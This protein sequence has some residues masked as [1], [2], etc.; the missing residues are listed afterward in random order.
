MK[1]SAF[2]GLNNVTDPIRLGLGWLSAADNVNITD[3]GALKKRGGFTKVASSSFSGAFSTFDYSRMYVVEAGVLMAVASATNRTPLISG[4]SSAPMF[5]TEIND[6][7]FYTNGVDSGIIGPDNTVRPWAWPTPPQPIVSLNT[8]SLDAGTYQVRY[9]YVL[10]GGRTTGSSESTDIAVGTG[11]ALSITGIPQGVPGV[12]FTQVY[13]A[14]ANS[15]VYQLAATTKQTSLFWSQSPDNLGQELHTAFLDPLPDGVGPVQAWQGR[16]YAA[17][18]FPELDQ[19]VVWFT[20]PLGFHLFNYNSAFVMVPGEV[21]MLTSHDKAL[22]LG[23]RE[24]IYAYDGTSLDQLAPYGVVPGGHASTDPSD[25]AVYFWS[26]RG[27]CSALPFTNLTE[28]QVSVAPGIQAGGAI[29][30]TGGQKRYVVALRQGGA[31]YNNLS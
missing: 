25:G 11:Q 4:L 7:V 10:E 17:Q 2:N 21:V 20:K 24:R 14:P 13:I 30:Q 28:R 6:Q 26:T 8:G 27:V 15:A 19:S 31:A 16:I 29:V 1:I 22:I 9:V 5:W 18:Y 3:T 23:T 12:E